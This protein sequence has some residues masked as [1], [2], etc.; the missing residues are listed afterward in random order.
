MSIFDVFHISSSFILR[1]FLLAPFFVLSLP[2]CICRLFYSF[3]TI[4]T[5]PSSWYLSLLNVIQS[6]LPAL[7]QSLASKVLQ[8]FSETTPSMADLFCQLLL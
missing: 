4:R 8:P 7:S 1:N 5:P 6:Y 2:Y 3:S